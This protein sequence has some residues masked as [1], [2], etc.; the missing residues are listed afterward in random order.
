MP[1]ERPAR[2]FSGTK[3]VRAL[4]GRARARYV[5]QGD[6]CLPIATYKVLVAA[7][8]SSFVSVVMALPTKKAYDPCT[9]QRARRDCN[10]TFGLELCW[11]PIVQSALFR[12]KAVLTRTPIY[13]LAGR[14]FSLSSPLFVTRAPSPRAERLGLACT[15]LGS[16]ALCSSPAGGSDSHG[17]VNCLECVTLAADQCLIAT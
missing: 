13:S 4:Q 9:S 8:T 17:N 3:E 2:K 6:R 10:P 14:F 11:K 5:R 7:T 16:I 15:W 12:Q 1:G